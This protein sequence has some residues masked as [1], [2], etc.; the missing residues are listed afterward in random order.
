MNGT[1]V[2]TGGGT[3]GHIYPGLAVIQ[4]LRSRGFD[5]RIVWIGS[6]KELD[7]SIVEAEGLE[8][9]AIPSGKLRRSIS[10]KNLTDAFRVAGGYFAARRLLKQ[11]GPALVFSKGGYVSV[12]VCR[13]AAS[14]RIPYFTH[15]SDTSPG[16]ATKMNARKAE[17]VLLSWP[18]TQ[19]MLPDALRPKSIVT[20][21]PVRPSI[22]SG[23]AEKGRAFV[24]APFGM[25]IV[26]F[27]GGSQGSQ[28]INDIVKA[29]LP[30][31]ADVA[32]VVHQTG[33]GLF[34]P[35]QQAQRP[36]RYLAL[37]Y[38]DAQMNDILAASTI[39]AG[40]AGAGTIWEC[41]ALGKPMVLIPLAGSGTRGDQVENAL[42]AEKA[43]AAR[44][45]C[46]QEAEPANVLGALLAYLQDQALLERARVAAFSL[47][48]IRT[49]DGAL[50]SSASYIADLLMDRISAS[51]GSAAGA[52]RHTDNTGGNSHEHP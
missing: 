6:K 45:L 22:L 24:Q 3:G 51:S 34:D 30:A 15:E 41:A 13:A 28:Q 20:G 16:L 39:V 47:S 12:P 48:G 32:Y 21:N 27:T 35:E 14:L 33:R 17:A 1:I 23:S 10:L 25:P 50:T 4:A 7:R 5:G 49:S 52:D 36:G 44:C 37:P 26:F 11:I 8:Y 19:Q 31:L 2:F 42:M 29:I 46:D 43:G 9:R 38:I 40:R 18:Q